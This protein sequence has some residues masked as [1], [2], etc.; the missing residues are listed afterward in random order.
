MFF[1][2]KISIYEYK[3]LLTRSIRDLQSVQSSIL[4]FSR[5]N[6]KEI[7]S[8]RYILETFKVI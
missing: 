2:F 3:L 1:F 6:K 8:H 5:R 4:R 7:Y